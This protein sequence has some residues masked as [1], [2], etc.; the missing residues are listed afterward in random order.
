M[1]AV[2]SFAIVAAGL[3]VL[4]LALAQPRERTIEE[5]VGALESGLASLETRFGVQSTRPDNLGGGSDLA[6]ALRITALE[7][8]LERVEADLQRVRNLAETAAREA[9][10]A[11]QA[12]RDAAMRTR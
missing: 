12:A 3:C 6:A 10:D 11:R 8:S 1:R 9:A 4:T 2:L 5:R 7:R